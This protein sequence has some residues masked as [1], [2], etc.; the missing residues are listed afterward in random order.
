[1]STSRPLTVPRNFA[2][3]STAILHRLLFSATP[4]I[5]SN[6]DR[7][8]FPSLLS[9]NDDVLESQT[10]AFGS[11]HD[12]L[13]IETKFPHKG[14]FALDGRKRQFEANSDQHL[15]AFQSKYFDKD[16][17]SMELNLFSAV[18][19]MTMEPKNVDAILSTRL[20]VTNCV[21]MIDKIPF[22]SPLRFQVFTDSPL[23]LAICTFTLQNTLSVEAVIHTDQEHRS[24]LLTSSPQSPKYS[25]LYLT[26]N[27]PNY[28]TTL[29]QLK[30]HPKISPSLEKIT[31]F[32]LSS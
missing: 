3:V 8:L 7:G 17:S 11:L 29:E 5:P 20:E 19:Y 32:L 9:A 4:I 16:R 27:S 12:C 10:M 2:H 28:Q 15:M 31:S 6:A 30:R 21:T 18:G 1:M 24:S 13:P 14:P 22:D 26:T 25:P 23:L